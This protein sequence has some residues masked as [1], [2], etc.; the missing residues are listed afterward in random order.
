M[1]DAAAEY[2]DIIGRP[3]H[4]SKKH[5][6]MA[7]LVRAAQFA[8]FAALTGYDELIRESARETESCP[9][10][11]GDGIRELNDKLV[12]LLGQE[13][14]PEAVFTYFIPDEKKA[15]GR[16]AGVTGRVMRYDPCGRSITL[17]SGEQMFLENITRIECDAYRT[18]PEQ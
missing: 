5:P 2:G 12:F 10:L 13:E 15:G 7:R 4:E 1:T 3:H 9:G 17:D 16:Y 6:R 18:L 11:D 14:P 8:P